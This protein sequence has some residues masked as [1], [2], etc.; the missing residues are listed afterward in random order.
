MKYIVLNDIQNILLKYYKY[1]IGYLILITAFLFIQNLNGILIDD[2]LFLD[3]VGLEFSSNCDLLTIILFIINIGI[4]LIITINTF[5]NN[6]KDGWENIFLRI[7]TNKW[8]N[9]KLISIILLN[10][11]FTVAMY[12]VIFIYFYINNYIIFNVIEYF[13]AN[14]IIMTLIE[15]IFLCLYLFCKKIKYSLI[16]VVLMG[17]ISLKKISI[18]INV[19]MENSLYLILM[20]IELIILLK[21]LIKECVI[22]IFE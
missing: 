7:E 13:L 3:V 12:L 5:V 22:N 9:Y 15:I 17:I 4:H 1:I 21:I 14:I 10:V 19:I 18:N 2:K 6:F 16:L 11:L 20:I 8:F